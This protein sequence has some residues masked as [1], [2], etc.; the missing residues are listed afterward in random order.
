MCSSDLDARGKA[1]AL[2]DAAGVQLGA[3]TSTVEGGGGAI[4]LAAGRMEDTKAASIEPGTQE[5]Q[6][7]VTV[8]FAVS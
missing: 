6:A 2:A 3:M 1:Q 7:T 4:P 5:I 8:T